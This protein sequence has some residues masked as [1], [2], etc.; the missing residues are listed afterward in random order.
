[1]EEV[2]DG[3]RMGRNEG[4]WE[5]RVCGFTAQI[6]AIKLCVLVSC[7][8]SCVI[9]LFQTKLPND[10]YQ[11]HS[12]T[13]ESTAVFTSYN[14]VFRI[15]VPLQNLIFANYCMSFISYELLPESYTCIGKFIG[16]LT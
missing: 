15:E 2:R 16:R 14:G 12:I 9:D 6:R 4:R 13:Q 3:I 1:M 7:R 8:I 5:G 11:H 10:T